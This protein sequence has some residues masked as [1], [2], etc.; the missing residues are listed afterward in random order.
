MAET[1]PETINIGEKIDIS[2]MSNE[3][4]IDM[5]DEYK[6]KKDDETTPLLSEKDGGG[7]TKYRF[8][9]NTYYKFNDNIFQLTGGFFRNQLENFFTPANFK[10]FNLRKFNLNLSEN[11]IRQVLSGGVESII[12]LINKSN[13]ENKSEIVAALKGSK[14]ILNHIINMLLNPKATEFL[15]G[16]PETFPII[17]ASQPV[18]CGK[19][20]LSIALH[21]N[22]I[23]KLMTLAKPHIIIEILQGLFSHPYQNP[24]QSG[25]ELQY[26][27]FNN[28]NQNGGNPLLLLAARYAIRN[29]SMAMGIAESFKSKLGE[30][31]GPQN[32]DDEEEIRGGASGEQSEGEVG[33]EGEGEGSEAGE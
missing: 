32:D 8:N 26:Y 5:Y 28:H 6:N 17:C 9:N 29:P 1:K 2:D 13:I 11:T 19:L 18:N 23:N 25:G 4:T 10:G 16:L 24:V 3:Y 21:R 14:D 20:G 15:L 22:S 33:S 31:Q 7:L 27:R 12:T 30:F